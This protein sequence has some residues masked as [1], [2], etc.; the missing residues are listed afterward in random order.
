MHLT[1]SILRNNGTQGVDLAYLGAGI[2]EAGGIER[3]G[4]IRGIGRIRGIGGM[5]EMKFDLI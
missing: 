2:G 4:G 3:M 1:N 5:G